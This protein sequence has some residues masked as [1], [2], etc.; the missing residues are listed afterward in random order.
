MLYGLVSIHCLF[1]HSP[2]ENLCKFRTCI[3]PARCK[4]GKNC[5][6]FVTSPVMSAMRRVGMFFLSCMPFVDLMAL[7]SAAR[8]K[9]YW[10]DRRSLSAEYLQG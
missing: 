1:S 2:V 4:K 8:S 3:L 5:L 6:L 7:S 9:S 10:E